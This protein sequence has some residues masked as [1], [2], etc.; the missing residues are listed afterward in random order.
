MKESPVTLFK[1]FATELDPDKLQHSFLLSLIKIQNVERGSIWIKRED[2]YHC[3]EAVG[4]QSENIRGVEI[5]ALHPSIVGWVIENGKM[6]V[7][8]PQRDVRHYRELEE[9]LVV[10]SS[11][12]L[13]FPLLLSD[14]KVYGALQI[15]DTSK[16][17]SRINL[18]EKYLKHLKDL[19]DI[20]SIALSNAI[21]HKREVEKARLL[22]ETLDE[23]RSEGIIVGQSQSFLKAMELIKGY[24]RTD[25]PVLV[26]GESGTG[27]DL[28]ADKLY[29]F[30]ERKHQPYLV[31]NCSAIPESLL[32]S[33]LFGYKKGA[34]SG[35]VKDK[36][37]LFEAADGGTVFLDEIGDMPMKLQARILRVIQNGEIKPLGQTRVKQ[38]DIRIIS[39]T[40]KDISK[41]V[42]DGDF[43]EDLFYRLS[44][45]PLSL[46]PLRE[47]VDDIP[48]LFNHFMKREAIRLDNRPKTVSPSALGVLMTFKWPGNIRELENLVRYLVVAVEGDTVTKND[49]PEQF[50]R[51]YP[52]VDVVADVDRGTEDAPRGQN[53]VA[54]NGFAG[55]SWKEIEF[56]YARYL[57]QKNNWNLTWAA[58]DAD[59]N[60]STFVSKLRR[61]GISK[62]PV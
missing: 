11:L 4:R 62:K 51:S 29:L 58:R 6:T 10:K 41:M 14:G 42:A 60:R 39:A 23:I 59:L 20:G 37:G 50:V 16:D 48:I 46:P 56:R 24:A 47:R 34:F 33:E 35:A 22:E 38:V 12:I 1:S 52:A 57:L 36:I 13:C 30:S 7:S 32:E 45:L 17:K 26:T 27:K 15:I 49:L 44:V 8:D 54:E 31:Q 28:V 3:V 5:S 40:N 61:L 19:V 2:K 53:G 25:F 18:D 9:N 43:R 21:I 55:S